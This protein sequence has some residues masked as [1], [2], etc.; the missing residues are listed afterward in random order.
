MCGQ[1]SCGIAGHR[2]AGRWLRVYQQVEVAGSHHDANLRTPFPTGS[3]AGAL[4]APVR[5]RCVF[6]SGLFSPRGSYPGLSLSLPLDMDFHDSRGRKGWTVSLSSSPCWK[7]TRHWAQG[8]GQGALLL[9]LWVARPSPGWAPTSIE[10]RWASGWVGGRA[11]CT[12]VP[13]TCR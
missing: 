6:T 4:Q 1:G 8:A 12:V 2:A 5:V 11:R 9:L 3:R 7:A 10:T 13:P